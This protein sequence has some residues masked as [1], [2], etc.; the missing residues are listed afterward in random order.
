MDDSN[1]I[2]SPKKASNSSKLQNQN[3][4][5]D[6]SDSSNT[7]KPRM[8]HA[9][10]MKRI[11]SKIANGNSKQAVSEMDITQQTVNP[12]LQ[13]TL[14]S[15]VDEESKEG[16]SIKSKPNKKSDQISKIPDR[17]RSAKEKM[18]L[19]LKR[20]KLQS[21]DGNEVRPSLTPKS[22]SN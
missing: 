7:S 8:T 21:I 5:G 9:E 12:L 14:K 19:L 4:S 15:S 10:Q 13:E 11:K 3:M 20:G 17:T 16:F 18:A 1:N 22:I 2:L 6:V